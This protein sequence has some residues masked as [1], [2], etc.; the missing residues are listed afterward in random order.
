[1]ATTAA[2]RR[3]SEARSGAETP[4][5]AIARLLSDR[6]SQGLPRRVSDPVV[7]AKLAAALKNGTAQLSKG[8]QREA[9]RLLRGP[10]RRAEASQPAPP[11]YGRPSQLRKEKYCR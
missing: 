5:D 6:V 4:A 3:K 11:A 8:D 2:T 9:L 7:V 1:M 10:P